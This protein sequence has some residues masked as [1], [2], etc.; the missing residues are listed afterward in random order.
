MEEYIL[1]IG[2]AAILATVILAL[3][4]LLQIYKQVQILERKL[5]KWAR[6]YKQELYEDL[7]SLQRIAGG[8]DPINAVIA[9]K[10]EE[11]EELEK[12]LSEEE[13]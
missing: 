7:R 10:T 13:E 9:A 2:E 4:S 12:I 5:K 6:F 1:M 3:F 8:L 11:I